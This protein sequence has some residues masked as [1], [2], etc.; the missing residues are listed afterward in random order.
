MSET[1]IKSSRADGTTITV[2][3]M[4]GHVM[5]IKAGS[6]PAS[7]FVAIPIEDFPAVFAALQT[8]INENR[9]RDSL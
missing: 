2:T 4:D 5:I 1:V 8:I 3:E 7:F 9:E 6:H